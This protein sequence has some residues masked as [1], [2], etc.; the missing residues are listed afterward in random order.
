MP[1]TALRAPGFREGLDARAAA[2]LLI[3][4]V[5]AMLVSCGPRPSGKPGAETPQQELRRLAAQEVDGYKGERLGS[6]TDFR[7]NSI[8]GPQNVDIKT[9]RLSVKGRVGTPLSLAYDDVLALPRYTKVLTVNCVEGW[10]V[11]VLVEGVRLVDV[12]EKASYDRSAKVVI[13]RAADGYSSSLPLE[14]IVEN[15]ILLGY[16]MNGVR[17]PKARGFPFE[18]MAEDK[19]GYKWVKWVEQI[20]VSDDTSF[21]GYWESRGYDNDA[22]LP[23]AK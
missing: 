4:L 6:V 23:S 2:A 20:E 3:T 7:E 5:T 11:K 1:R 13:F 22:T 17:L 15:D 18:V 14:Y 12:L 19:W 9:Y 8:K 16:K 10:S 21:R